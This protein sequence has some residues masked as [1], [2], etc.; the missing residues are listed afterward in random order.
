MC[1]RDQVIYTSKLLWFKFASHWKTAVSQD[2][3][4]RMDSVLRVTRQKGTKWPTWAMHLIHLL[5]LIGTYVKVSSQNG[6]TTSAYILMSLE[7]NNHLLASPTFW[8]FINTFTR[9]TWIYLY[10]DEDWGAQPKPVS[11]F[12]FISTKRCFPAFSVLSSEALR[13]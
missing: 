6:N 1:R 10:T 12:I 8:S 2:R 5:D 11:P 4:K 9:Y 3:W 13:L 7:S